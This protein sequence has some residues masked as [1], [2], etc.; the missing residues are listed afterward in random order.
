MCT[1]LN[2]SDQD[3][4]IICNNSKHSDSL[5]VDIESGGTSTDTSQGGTS[6]DTSQGDCV[7][8]GSPGSVVRKRDRRGSMEDT[9]GAVNHWNH[10]NCHLQL[11]N[12]ASNEWSCSY[13]SYNKN[14]SDLKK[15]L[16]CDTPRDSKH[17][18]TL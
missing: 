11:M 3:K 9:G 18:G 8:F 6:T 13:C 1:F 15:C 14:S 10:W 7:R 16:M 5:L 2:S 4:C 12:T 17:R